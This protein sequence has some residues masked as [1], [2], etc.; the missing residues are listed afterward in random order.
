MNNEFQNQVV[1]VTGAAGSL[2]AVIG[3]QFAAAGAR[4]YRTD[5]RP[6]P[7]PHFLAGDLTAPAFVA[8][9]VEHILNEAGR[10]DV[11]VNNAGICPRTP[12]LEITEAEWQQVFAVNLTAAF[13]LSQACLR[14]MMAQRSG[15]II[16]V[17]SLAGQVGGIAVGAHYSATKAALE[18]LTKTL[19][20]HGAPYG[21]R[22]NAVAPGIIESEMTR[23]AG[24][25]QLAAF[26]Q[27]IP[28]GR[29]GSPAEVAG[30]ILFLASP[31]AS[32]ITGVTLDINGGLKMG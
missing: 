3:E 26:R 24:D 27:S 8:Q 19:A 15:C 16:N 11:L 25:A 18:C 30:P 13:R 20:R 6:V 1:L 23:Q 29:L 17:A 4:V 2:G 32:Y 7:Q 14:P 9:L 22:A 21:I 5:L 12:L 28:L 10:L 31:R